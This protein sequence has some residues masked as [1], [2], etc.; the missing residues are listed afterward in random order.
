MSE[1]GLEPQYVINT[2]YI[3]GGTPSSINEE[4]IIDVLDTIKGNFKVKNRRK[5]EK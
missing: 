3:G 4:H 1:H 5:R 2:I